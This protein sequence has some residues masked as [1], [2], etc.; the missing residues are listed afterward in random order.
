MRKFL[1][2]I[3]IILLSSATLSAAEREVV[4]NCIWGKLSA[5]LSTPDTA[6][7]T[8]LLIVAG[9]GPTDRNGN[10]GAGLNTFCYK[11][12]ADDI[13]AQGYA[14]L[15]YD[16]RGI[17]L[18]RLPAE[19]TEEEILFTDYIDDARRCVEYLRTEGYKRV[20]IAG[21]S[22]G[23]TIALH[24]AAEPDT[25]DA[26]VLLCAPGY[27]ID[28]ILIKQLSAQLMPA[29]IGLMLRAEAIIRS[30]KQGVRVAEEDIPQELLALFRPSVQPFIISNM[31]SNPEALAA[32]SRCPMLIITGGYDIQVTPDNG[33]KLVA[34]APR[35]RHIIFEKMSHV[36]KTA[37]SAERMEQLLSVYTNTQL[38]L[39]EG[40]TAE[41]T[42]FLRT[43]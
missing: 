6:T 23:G 34:A 43:L 18:S 10:S 41:I 15:R 29:H 42:T 36:L 31:Q 39:T 33:D 21:H 32:E 13:T 11:L 9:S 2:I 19:T 14:V 5:T 37:D 3:T 38:P 4:I 35:A 8:A 40:I 1:V 16:K 17:G 27:P 12:L 26:A 20:V 30:L 28:T 22:E 25:V 7:D 24:L